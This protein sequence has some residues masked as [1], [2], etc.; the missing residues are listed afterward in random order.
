M[1]ALS[2]IALLLA[3]LALGAPVGFALLV[4]GI[5]GLVG[6]GGI[7][8]AMG[9]LRTAPASAASGYEL[10]TI[11]MFMVMAEFVILSGVADG[12]FRAAATWMGR[13]PGGLGVATAL[14]GAGFAAISGSST[15]SAATLSST[16]IPAMLRQGYEPK[17]ACGV[18]AISGTLA[19]LIPPSI[20]LVLYGIVANVSIG[21]LLIAGVLPG[22]LVTITIILTVFYLVWRDPAV[23]P[24][25]R[26]HTLRE[27]LSTLREVGPML[28]LFAAVTGV[29][30][31]GIATPT[32]ASAM[33]AFGAMLLAWRSGNLDLRSMYTSATRAGHSTCMILMII[34]GAQVFG[35]FITLTQATQQLVSWVHSLALP[36][37]VVIVALLVL[38]MLLGSI[39]DQAAIIILAVPVV[40]PVVTSL[41]Y[42]PVW[43][44]VIMIVT[45]EVGL[46]TPPIGLNA[47][48]VARY[49][50]RPLGEVFR[51]VWPHVIAH[52]IAIAIFVIFPQTI[53]WLPST[54]SR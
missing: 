49:T 26:A 51:G 5:C 36:G 23:A 32:E 46:V 29:I 33:G 30:Y 35:Y 27:K 48:V 37:L 2:I 31:S 13:V 18:V 45:A 22:I 15:A 20:A 50:G 43:F 4:S 42:D 10:I 41:G 7:D 14:A 3:L 16:T 54:M 25:G 11:P 34:L 9:V 21:K 17:M 52:L 39:M 8:M 53:L 28:A 44:G 24:M 38:K 40:L 1:L 12:L 6:M 19:M 47:F